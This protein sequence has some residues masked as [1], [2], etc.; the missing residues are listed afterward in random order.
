[1]QL[2][3]TEVIANLL[4]FWE[5]KEAYNKLQICA[6]ILDRTVLQSSINIMDEWPTLITHLISS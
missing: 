3:V 2:I 4:A 6:Q 5:E 1:M